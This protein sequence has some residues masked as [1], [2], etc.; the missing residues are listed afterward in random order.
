M[1]HRHSCRGADA[2]YSLSSILYSLLS[3]L[4]P[5]SS[6]L[7]SLFSILLYSLFSVL[8][9]YYAPVRMMAMRMVMSLMSMRLSPFRSA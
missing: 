7:Y 4:Y 1:K 6:I 8:C 5:L 9:S 2:I 3:I